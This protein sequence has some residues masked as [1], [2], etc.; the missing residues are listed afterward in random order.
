[1][2]T[3]NK[4]IP[5]L[6]SI[7]W[8]SK[9]EINRRAGYL[10]QDHIRKMR[11]V[12]KE[13]MRSQNISNVV[14]AHGFIQSA[15]HDTPEGER[16]IAELFSEVSF[17]NAEVRTGLIATIVACYCW[18]LDPALKDIINPWIPLMDLF[19]MGYTVTPED[20]PDGQTV[21]LVVGYKNQ[22]TV[23]HIM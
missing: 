21:S 14:E 17:K 4:L 12:L 18:H 16:L 13:I 20:A 23:F 19:G 2:I 9:N 7:E 22:E 10:I 8:K 6:N 15:G 5:W 11:H 1:M 3:R